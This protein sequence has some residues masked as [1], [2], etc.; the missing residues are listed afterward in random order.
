MS[1]PLA[2]EYW[3][4]VTPIRLLF[5]FPLTAYVY[6]Y[7]PSTFETV[8]SS[9]YVGKAGFNLKN[10][11]IF[12]WCFLETVLWFWVG[13]TGPNYEEYA[14]K[15]QVYVSMKEQRTQAARRVIEKRKA[16]SQVR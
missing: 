16:E 10:G 11:V 6:L 7:Q 8:K 15:V 1:E 9:V 2:V 14:H 13:H 3:S 12:S 4:S 5:L